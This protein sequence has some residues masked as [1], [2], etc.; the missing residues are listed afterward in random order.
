[1][2]FERRCIPPWPRRVVTPPRLPEEVRIVVFHGRPE[3]RRLYG[4]TLTEPPWWKRLV[5]RL[6]PDP[7]IAEHWR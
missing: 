4:G 5:E 1:M 3:S 2:S 7:W 6:R